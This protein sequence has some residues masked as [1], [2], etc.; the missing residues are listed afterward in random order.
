MSVE[1][2]FVGLSRTG[3]RPKHEAATFMK[4]PERFRQ[5]ISLPKEAIMTHARFIATTVLA[6][7]LGF[8]AANSAKADISSEMLTMKPLHG[9][10]FDLG[11]KRAVSYFSSVAGHC[12]LVL[13]YAEPLVWDTPPDPVVTRFET[14]LLAGRTFR[15]ASHEN[16]IADFR[17][18]AHAKSMTIKLLRHV[19]I[20]NK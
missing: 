18:G 5:F 20:T 8:N 15:Y 6:L 14:D 12:K 9:V 3:L 11:T 1:E 16:A 13:T 2:K 10:S 7:V 19:A 4:S 17:C